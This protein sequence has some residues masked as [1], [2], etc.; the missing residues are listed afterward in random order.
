MEYHSASGFEGKRSKMTRKKSRRAEV[1]FIVKLNNGGEYRMLI[2]RFT[3]IGGD[4][5]A[6]IIAREHQNGGLI[7][8]GQIIEVSRAPLSQQPD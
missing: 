7:P 3:L 8:K 6:R 5:V 1:A 4:H 2:D